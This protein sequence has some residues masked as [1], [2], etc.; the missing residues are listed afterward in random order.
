MREDDAYTKLQLYI[1]NLN[2]KN[3]NLCSQN[4]PRKAQPHRHPPLSKLSLLQ[5]ILWN[6]NARILFLFSQFLAHLTSEILVVLGRLHVLRLVTG[7]P[8]LAVV[9]VSP[10]VGVFLVF[11]GSEAHGDSMSWC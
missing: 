4:I 7:C 3:I 2:I 11:A 9:D 10:P 6:S 5:N 1:Y 8:T